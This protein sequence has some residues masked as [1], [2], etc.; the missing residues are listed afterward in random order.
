MIVITNDRDQVYGSKVP[1]LKIKIMEK[2]VTESGQ[3]LKIL[4]VTTLA[5]F[6]GFRQKEQDWLG[7][8]QY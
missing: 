4:F 2:E 3:D 5:L 7:K 6:L 8:V 1:S